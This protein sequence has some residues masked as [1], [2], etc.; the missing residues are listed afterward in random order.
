MR[1]VPERQQCRTRDYLRAILFDDIPY[2]FGR[3]L[4]LV[5]P[6]DRGDVKKDL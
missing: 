5:F 2:F 1:G 3:A 4:G 6:S